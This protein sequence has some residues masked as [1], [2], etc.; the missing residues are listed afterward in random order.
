M[1][2][3]TCEQWFHCR[4]VGLTL[5]M[6]KELAGSAP[7]VIVKKRLDGEVECAVVCEGRAVGCATSGGVKKPAPSRQIHQL[8]LGGRELDCTCMYVY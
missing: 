4:G 5:Q 2:C 6:A 1:I 8:I 7:T 3:T